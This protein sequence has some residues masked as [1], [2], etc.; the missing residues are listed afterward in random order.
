MR[1]KSKGQR[2]V[3]LERSKAQ[4]SIGLET[5]EVSTV[6][7]S[8]HSVSDI[9]EK[10]LSDSLTRTEEKWAIRGQS[11]DKTNEKPSKNVKDVDIVVQTGPVLSNHSLKDPVHDIDDVSSK[12]LPSMNEDHESHDNSTINITDSQSLSQSTESLSN[13]SLTIESS[14][15]LTSSALKPFRPTIIENFR[16]LE[17]L[18]NRIQSRGQIPHW[19]LIENSLQMLSNRRFRLADLNIIATISPESYRL[20]WHLASTQGN[21]R[22]ESQ[23]VIEILRSNG[24]EEDQSLPQQAEQ[25]PIKSTALSTAIPTRHRHSDRIN[26][27]IMK[28]DD[29]ISQGKSLDAMALPMMIPSKPQMSSASSGA[30]QM[31]S[32]VG[33]LSLK[34]KHDDISREKELQQ[35]QNG[36]LTGLRN[37]AKYR[38]MEM[39]K[40]LSMETDQSQLSTAIKR[41]RSLERLALLLR[42]LS[43]QERR[44]HR[45]LDEFVRKYSIES[46]V[47]PEELRSR[48][49]LLYTVCPEYINISPPND[50][51]DM[52]TIRINLDCSMAVVQQKIAAAEESA[53]KQLSLSASSMPTN[54]QTSE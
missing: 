26:H 44:L 12:A 37:L 39:N 32:V 54:P 6:V 8:F 27:F 46:R 41:Y 7:K 4:K 5:L 50:V 16:Y 40:K 48:L 34:R 53:R 13:Q 29:W 15:G 45:S 3:E 49:Y 23:L 35:F 20:S 31:K 36:D 17:I 9:A 43:R 52:E 33:S 24:N 2:L 14:H 28:L 47:S 51:V 38:E 42:S 30:K 1:R 19:Y 21:Q 10:G 25:E 22:K 11:N 18:I